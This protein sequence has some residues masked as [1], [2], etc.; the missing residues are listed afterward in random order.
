MAENIINELIDNC[1][2]TVSNQDDNYEI[3][4][5]RMHYPI[6]ITS[7]ITNE[8]G[9]LYVMTNKFKKIWPLTSHYVNIVGAKCNNNEYAFSTIKSKEDISVEE[10]QQKY[11]ERSNKNPDCFESLT[12]WSYYNIINTEK[13]ES[14]SAFIEQYNLI[15]YVENSIICNRTQSMLIV[16]LD[17]STY[18]TEK[19]TIISKIKS[20]IKEKNNELIKKYNGIIIL[21]N[22]SNSGQSFSLRRDIVSVI[23]S[24]IVMSSNDAV[25]SDDDSNY[26]TI[27][28]LIYSGIP[29]TVAQCKMKKP[30]K[31]ISLFLI[32]EMMDCLSTV[33]N[34]RVSDETGKVDWESVLRIKDG[35]I[36][37][38]DKFLST[39]LDIKIDFEILKHMPFSI[40]PPENFNI[41]N[42]KI[43]SIINYAVE[44]SLIDYICS[45][46]EDSIGKDSA[47]IFFEDYEKGLFSEVSA[48]DFSNLDERSVTSILSK[49]TNNEPCKELTIEKYIE[50]YA[51][52][53][54]YKS[55]LIPRIEEIMFSIK[56]STQHLK[57][58]FYKF[59]ES[60]IPYIPVSG[61][62][63]LG[64]RYK[65]AVRDYS[66]TGNGIRSLKYVF[67]P[68]NGDKEFATQICKCIQE[69]VTTNNDLFN[70]PFLE[71]WTMML[72]GTG[73]NLYSTLYNE[74]GK[75]FDDRIFYCT[76]YAF[77]RGA[78]DVYMFHT[79]KNGYATDLY[80][81]L[82]EN[83][84]NNSTITYL[85]T[86]RDSSIEAIRL[87]K[88]DN[89]LN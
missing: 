81:Y 29:L 38:F 46:I 15:D 52:Y 5:N 56:D 3:I 6:F 14:L 59:K 63:H 82:S 16:V 10:I 41:E 45:L 49:I 66:R 39:K 61:F 74:F 65:V 78:L 62:D 20:F 53:Y 69:L 25:G 47:D 55:I 12:R 71:H 37:S 85:N 31:D 77:P 11:L 4:G 79:K 86:G 48:T 50:E 8:D 60:F 7:N 43:I 88:L 30:Y 2:A 58:K 24:I 42:E 68:G 75:A 22:K 33:V 40:I 28:S 84:I 35:R 51:K 73:E 44:D 23:S 80:K 27:N 76:N 13:I 36:S 57:S 64:N 21:S 89:E 26:N 9:E 83:N 19:R 17:D 72:Q 54:A 18:S 67:R 87:F 70:L 34:Q 32:R 1:I